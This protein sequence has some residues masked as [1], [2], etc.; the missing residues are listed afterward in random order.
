MK[1]PL[2]Y[3]MC[4][5]H[6][7]FKSVELFMYI[8]MSCQWQV[9]NGKR[10]NCISVY[11]LI[12]ELATKSSQWW[13]HVF[14]E[15]ID[16]GD[17]DFIMFQV[18]APGF[19]SD[20]KCVGTEFCEIG[21]QFYFHPK[22]VGVGYHWLEASFPCFSFLSSSVLYRG[23]HTLFLSSCIAK[24][25]HSEIGFPCRP[26]LCDTLPLFMKII[27]VSCKGV[28]S[29]QLL[30]TWDLQSSDRICDILILF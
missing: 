18:W 13:C 1:G 7:M 8:K 30:T 17:G 14:C 22:R 20:S 23:T 16:L 27:F 24:A 28:L 29:L 26:L 12:Q 2:F 21:W 6:L 3:W 11:Q 10:D 25:L 15:H 4:W 9:T 5:C 19:W